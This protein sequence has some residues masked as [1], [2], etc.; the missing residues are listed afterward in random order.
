MAIV[1]LD[2]SISASLNRTGDDRFPMSEHDWLQ[3]RNGSNDV[4]RVQVPAGKKWDVHV[5]VTIVE[6]DA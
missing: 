4:L 1:L 2:Q 3:I 6:T 5:F